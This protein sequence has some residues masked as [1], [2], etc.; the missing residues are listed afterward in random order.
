MVSNP[1][2]AAF[3]TDREEKAALGSGAKTSH[4]TRTRYVSV[5]RLDSEDAR[6]GILAEEQARLQ[7]AILE[8]S[9]GVAG[10]AGRAGDVLRLQRRLG[11]GRRR[12]FAPVADAA[13]RR[14]PRPRRRH[15][16]GAGGDLRRVRPG[17]EFTR[18]RHCLSPITFEA[19]PA[20]AA[21]S[22]VVNARNAKTS[23]AIDVEPGCDYITIQ[24]FTIDGTAGRIATYPNPATGSRSTGTHDRVLNN[25]VKNLDYGVAG[26][27]CNGA[28]NIVISGNTVYGVHNHGERTIGP[29]HLHRRRRRHR[30]PRQLPPRQRL[31]RPARQRR[32]QR[33]QHTR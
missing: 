30:G 26:I 27:H 22:V 21:G 24:G 17:V 2:S 18:L 7:S 12:L 4:L 3:S 16:R 1:S 19:D 33:G 8:V 13:K 25:V 6:Q 11:H 14:R 10:T 23:T 29:R 20:A 9:A 15:G 31:H 32:P 28:D 5:F